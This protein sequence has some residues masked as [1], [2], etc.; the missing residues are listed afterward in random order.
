MKKITLI[1]L[2]VSL[3]LVPVFAKNSLA[4]GVNLGTNAGLGIQY[5]MSDFDLVGNVGYGFFDG[6]LSVDGA[7]S[8]KVADFKIEQ[9]VF[10][11]TV[12]GG[13]YV[14]VPL[15]S[16]AKLGLALFVPVGVQYSLNNKDWPLDFYLRLAPG[17][18]LRPTPYFYM[19]AYV[20][21][22]WRFN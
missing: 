16:S 22:L 3:V 11:V 6:Y 1:V 15:S 21:A 7:A 18:W 4:L 17:Y 19:G 9:A 20:G 10:D 12:G 13:A 5:R 14:G 2:V 8:Y